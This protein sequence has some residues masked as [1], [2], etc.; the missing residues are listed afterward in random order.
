[1]HNND[2]EILAFQ[3]WALYIFI[4][5]GKLHAYNRLSEDSMRLCKQFAPSAVYT[6]KIAGKHN[7]SICFNIKM[8][9]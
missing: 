1:M 7:F 3:N 9:K 2:L 4:N 5:F 6:L 8:W